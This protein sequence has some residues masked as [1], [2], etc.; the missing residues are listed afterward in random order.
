MSDT[1]LSSLKWRFAAKNFDPSKPVSKENFQKIV[2]SIHLTPTS[3]GLQPYHVFVVTD[4]ETKLKLR[5]AAYDQPQI[6]EASHVLVFASR[7]DIK[8]RAETMIENL[9][10]GMEEVPEKLSEYFHMLRGFAS[11]MD[12]EAAKAWAKSQTYI[13]LGFAMAACAELH[14]DSCPMEGFMADQVNQILDIKEPLHTAVILP[15]GHRNADPDRPKFRFPKKE[16]FTA[17]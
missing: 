10:A 12:G 5:K 6:E 9:T 1:F 13:A 4:E 3:F 7:T 14:V 15:L 2:E 16:L 11:G 8:D 17:V